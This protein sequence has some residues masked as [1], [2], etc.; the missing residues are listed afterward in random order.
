M[1][2][3]K[4]Q[5]LYAA[6][7]CF[8][9]N[10]IEKTTY[11]NI[12]ARVSLQRRNSFSRQAVSHHFPNKEAIVKEIFLLM[13]AYIAARMPSIESLFGD[14]TP[15]EYQL[16]RLFFSFL[17]DEVNTY[18]KILRIM[19]FDQLY[20]KTVRDYVLHG[21]IEKYERYLNLCF[22]ALIERK[23]FKPFNTE[24]VS[25]IFFRTMFTYAGIAVLSDGEKGCGECLA[26]DSNWIIDSI[27]SGDQ[28]N[29]V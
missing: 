5:I 11:E 18:Y 16:R 20:N 17:P 13:D 3:T 19:F 2:V 21:L 28:P 23:V 9:E 4:R 29:T 10:G 26:K 7:D 1:K 27:L 8:S 12:A 25:R 6:I 15:K 24:S 22:D 14:D